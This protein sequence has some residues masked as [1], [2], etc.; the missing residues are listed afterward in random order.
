MGLTKLEED[1]Q[2]TAKA[3]GKSEKEVDSIYLSIYGGGSHP[4]AVRKHLDN[5]AL[6]DL[7]KSLETKMLSIPDGSMNQKLD[8]MFRDPCYCYV[9][10]GACAMTLGCHLPEP[11]VAMLKIVYTG[12]TKNPKALNQLRKALFGPGGFKDGEPYD[13][14]S[15]SLVETANASDDSDDEPNRAGFKMLNVINP[16]GLFDTG[17]GNSAA[18]VIL[19]ELRDRLHD[20]DTCGECAAPRAQDG[21]TLLRCAKCKDRKYC[22]VKCQ[23][24]HWDI[25]KKVC[26]SEKV[27]IECL[28]SCCCLCSGI[29]AVGSIDGLRLEHGSGTTK[30][31]ICP[32]TRSSY[33]L[34]VLPSMLLSVSAVSLL[35]YNVREDASRCR[36]DICVH[37]CYD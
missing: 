13:F 22:S 15:K 19:D 9:L 34:R 35:V 36:T 37:V 32:V 14:E 33:V 16:G 31:L 28:S 29:A 1:M 21:T 17:V 25:H 20:P 30:S 27:C 24:K 8:Y 3:A 6:V 4:D 26:R 2:A 10:L 11:Y 7:I 5:D 12:T 18:S 23:K